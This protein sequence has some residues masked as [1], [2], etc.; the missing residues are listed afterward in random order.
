MI[1][2]SACNTAAV[3]EAGTVETSTRAPNL[4]RRNSIVKKSFFGLG[5]QGMAHL[6]VTPLSCF[7]FL[8]FSF[9]SFLSFF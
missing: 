6:R 4:G 1:R 2:S 5:G 9:F 8:I 7:S 3:F